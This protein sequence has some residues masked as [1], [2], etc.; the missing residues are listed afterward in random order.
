MCGRNSK[1]PYLYS[2]KKAMGYDRTQYLHKLE[3]FLKIYLCC[4]V[5]LGPQWNVW[6]LSVVLTAS[7][8]LRVAGPSPY[9]FVSFSITAPVMQ[10]FP[11]W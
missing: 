3:G 7:S 10:L 8:L 11:P 1:S 9:V 4:A 2:R 6:N 5:L